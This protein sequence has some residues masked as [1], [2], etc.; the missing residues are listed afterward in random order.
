MITALDAGTLILMG[1]FAV[2]WHRLALL[3]FRWAQTALLIAAIVSL[4][5][6]RIAAGAGPAI[7]LSAAWLLAY[8]A[9][10]IGRRVIGED[11]SGAC[12]AGRSEN[13]N[14]LVFRHRQ[15]FGWHGLVPQAVR[16]RPWPGV[17]DHATPNTGSVEPLGK[18][19]SEHGAIA[20]TGWPSTWFCIAL[21]IVTG[22]GAYLRAYRLDEVMLSARSLQPDVVYYHE[23]ALQTANPFA[24]GN[25]SP[26]WSAL[27]SP[28]L[29]VIP[30]S[31]VSMRLISWISGIAMLALTGW[32]LGQ[33]LHPLV[34]VLTAGMLAVEPWLIDLC[35]EGLRE[36]AG[37]CL[38][39]VVLVLLLRPD[40]RARTPCWAGL[41]G[42]VLLLLRNI[43]VI[44]LLSVTAWAVWHQRWRGW[45]AA[46]ALLGPLLIVSPFYIN[47]YRAYGDAFAM[48]KR[49][50]RYHANGEFGAAPPPSLPM[51]TTQESGQNPFAGPPLSPLAYLVRYHTLRDFVS[52][53]TIGV[54]RTIMGEP[55][56]ILFGVWWRLACAGGVIASLAVPRARFVGSTLR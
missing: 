24:A 44:P 18:Q 19:A 42:G 52:H 30:D 21:A 43:S 32:G 56:T 3:S 33:L 14:K 54:S 16:P 9:A 41:A 34:G 48:E 31:N 55:F 1:C 6:V 11:K 10:A 20:C 35:C 51:P 26:L 28:L 29:R 36:E 22:T 5:S 53:Q 47:Q 7:D 46:A 23:H 17:P 8:T 2:V 50:A 38:W 49:D 13:A 40:A 4:A 15:F 12:S 25:K 37:I 45:R 39:M 27:H